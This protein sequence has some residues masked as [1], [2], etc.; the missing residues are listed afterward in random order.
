MDLGFDE[1]EE[2]VDEEE[3]EA[4]FFCEVDFERVCRRR[5]ACRVRRDVLLRVF[6]NIVVRVEENINAILFNDFFIITP[7]RKWL[8]IN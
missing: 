2:D 3:P 4:M 1:L 8:I 7:M 6:A 5:A